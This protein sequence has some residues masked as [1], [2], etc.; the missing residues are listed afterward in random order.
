MSEKRTNI[1]LFKAI[2]LGIGIA[3]ASGSAAAATLT[4]GPECVSVPATPG[5]EVCLS[6]NFMGLEKC[7]P[8]AGTSAMNICGTVKCNADGNISVVQG[9]SDFEPPTCNVLGHTITATTDVKCATTVTKNGLP[10]AIKT[11]G[12]LGPD[13][14]IQVCLRTR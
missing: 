10:I 9:A 7:I 1:L 12:P 3:L 2:G 11:V 14:E 8:L 4:I 5:T 6:D 13:D